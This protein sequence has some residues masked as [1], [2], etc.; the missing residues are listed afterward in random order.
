MTPWLTFIDYGR[1]GACARSGKGRLRQRYCPVC[2]C[3]ER[4]WGCEQTTGW[5][6]H[7]GREEISRTKPAGGDLWRKIPTIKCLQSSSIPLLPLLAF[8]RSPALYLTLAEVYYW[9]Q[10]MLYVLRMWNRIGR[11]HLEDKAW[12]QD[13]SCLKEHGV[14]TMEQEFGASAMLI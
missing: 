11:N 9:L 12:G 8:W 13:S 2:N 5:G 7:Q 4:N 14:I 1:W 10:T 3:N 6:Q